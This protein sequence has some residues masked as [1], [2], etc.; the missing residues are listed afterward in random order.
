VILSA[1]ILGIFQRVTMTVGNSG[2]S[3]H[4]DILD[5]G[6]DGVGVRDIMK[7]GRNSCICV[8]HKRRLGTGS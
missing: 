4:S 8:Y 1:R 2:K 3:V 6:S 7:N 5:V